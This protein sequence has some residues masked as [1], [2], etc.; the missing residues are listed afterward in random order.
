MTEVLDFITAPIR[1]LLGAASPTDAADASP[2][3]PPHAHH[4]PFEGPHQ[5]EQRLV[6]TVA[7]LEKAGQSLE[8]HAAV[9]Q[10]LVDQ[11]TQ[12]NAQLTAVLERTQPLERIEAD[13]SRVG[14]LFRRGSH[15][16]P[17][18]A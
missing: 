4:S 13:A 5:L 6:E 16:A 3:A 10:A 8:A 14:R 15:R 11:V 17:P 9:V 7:G 18:G 1:S 12:L 2:D